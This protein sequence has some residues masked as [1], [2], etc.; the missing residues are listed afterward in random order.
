MADCD[1]RYREDRALARRVLAGDDAAMEELFARSFAPLCR[2]ALL[3]V[4]GDA[5]LA[6]EMAQAT[7]C[8]ALERLHGYRGEAA[9]MT[10]LCT[11]CH[12]LVSDHFS[13]L[14]RRPPQV[15]LSE[16]DP[17]VR[18]ALAALAGHDCGPDQ[19]LCRREVARRVHGALQALPR[20]YS[21]ALAWRYLQG[22]S[23]HEIAERLELTNKAVEL[24]LWRARRA[25]RERFATAA[26]TAP[27]GL[28]GAGGTG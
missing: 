26:D 24:V 16:P 19:E 10:W 7:L 8:R 6:E 13:R 22:L 21:E 11:I 9:L 18:A 14:K 17:A 5:A 2:F 25:F 1:G 4:G 23:L 15:S 28:G 20:H 3:R 27:A 12:N